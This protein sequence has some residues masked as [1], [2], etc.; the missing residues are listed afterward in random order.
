MKTKQLIAVAIIIQKGNSIHRN[1]TKCTA[2]FLI[3]ERSH[4]N[5][6]KSWLK[7][8]WFE[9]QKNSINTGRR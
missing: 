3:Q 5:D 6:V 8:L 7:K 2:P 9:L 1:T 4:I